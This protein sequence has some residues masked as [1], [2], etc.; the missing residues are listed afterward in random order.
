M[1]ISHV[2]IVN[3]KQFFPNF[4]TLFLLMLKETNKPK[5]EKEKKIPNLYPLHYGRE[6]KA[7]DLKSGSR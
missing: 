3:Y 2:R 4:L 1:V 5:K 6:I 7:T